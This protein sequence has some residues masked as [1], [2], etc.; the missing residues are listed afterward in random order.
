MHISDA[1]FHDADNIEAICMLRQRA[2]TSVV[3]AY[4]EKL[5]IL[6]PIPCPKESRTFAETSKDVSLV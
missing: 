2:L 3:F 6:A 4:S 1:R 5:L